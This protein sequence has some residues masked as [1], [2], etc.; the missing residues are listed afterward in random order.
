[1]FYSR[2]FASFAGPIAVEVSKLPAKSAKN[3]NKSDSVIRVRWWQFLS[4]LKRLLS[5]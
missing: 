2:F 1:M 4:A 3:A 5:V